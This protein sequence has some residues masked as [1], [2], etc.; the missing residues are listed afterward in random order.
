M[1]RNVGHL[2]KIQGFDKPREMG[3][4]TPMADALA[5]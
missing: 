5:V 4:I 1:K 3:E 2:S